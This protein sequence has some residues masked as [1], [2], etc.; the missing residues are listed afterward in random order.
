MIARGIK[1]DMSRTDLPPDPYIEPQNVWIW[2]TWHRLH[3]DRPQFGGG[4]GPTVPGAIP[5]LTLRLWA[6][7]HHLTSGEFTMLD[8]CVQGM[9]AE[10]FDWW[11][12]RQKN[13]A[14]ASARRSPR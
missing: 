2:R 3:P 1:P 6:D 13:E 12:E 10:Y 14:A 11:S 5:W 7:S 8:R 9:D 4:M